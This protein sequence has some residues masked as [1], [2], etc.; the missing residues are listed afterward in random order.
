MGTQKRGPMKLEPTQPFKESPEPPNVL[1]TFEEIVEA[2]FGPSHC[3]F[4]KEKHPIAK[5]G[6]WTCRGCKKFWRDK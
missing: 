6:G 2:A 4:C 5:S 3:P 1:G